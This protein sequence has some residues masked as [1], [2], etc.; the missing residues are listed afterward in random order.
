MKKVLVCLVMLVL[1]GSV[2]WG[3]SE[4]PVMGGKLT[5]AT[6]SDPTGIDPAMTT[7]YGFAYI[8]RYNVF[9]SLLS[10]G[11]LAVPQPNLVVDWEFSEDGSKLTLYLKRGVKF[12]NGKDFTAADVKYTMDRIMDPSMGSPWAPQL[13]VVDSVEVVDPYTVLVNLKFPTPTILNRLSFIDVVCQEGI[14]A[15]KAIGTGAFYLDEWVPGDHITLKK[16]DDYWKSG[17]PYL[18]EIE[19]V[20]VRDADARVADLQAGAVD[21]VHA[22]D[23]KDAQ[24]I[25][26]TDGLHAELSPAGGL[27]AIYP[28]WN[29]WPMNNLECREALEYCVDRDSF[30]SD[31]LFGYGYVNPSLY[32]ES[33]WAFDPH[34]WDIYRPYDPEKAKALF[35]EAGYPRAGD[36]PLVLLTSTEFPEWVI[37]TVQIQSTL[38]S[39]GI[40]SEIVKMDL[41]AWYNELIAPAPRSWDVCY[42]IY[43]YGVQDPYF[44]LTTD[45]NGEGTAL[46]RFDIPGFY[47]LVELGSKQFDR[48]ERLATY[49]KIQE[50]LIENVAY[51]VVDHHPI[52]WGVNDRVRGI[53]WDSTMRAFFNRT[54]LSPE[55]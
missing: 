14:E 5:I 29:R 16:F 34:V 19:F 4:N 1:A 48:A 55:S 18:D 22:L 50:L 21:I 26:A 45:L 30:V 23:R 33:N 3:V 11:P 52:M 51:V 9:E 35:E 53:I 49:H 25:D 44:M 37:G 12:H 17:E 8:L 15:E 31:A 41:A 39:I 40:P 7:T 24:R 32:D 47:D 54:W 28:N 13:E 42:T 2:A 46:S 10:I 27:F 38:A 36:P 6:S 43:G 20:I